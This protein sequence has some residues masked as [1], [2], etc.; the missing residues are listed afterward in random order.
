MSDRTTNTDHV[1]NEANKAESTQ[2]KLWIRD[3]LLQWIDNEAISQDR[4]RA[5]M[6]N[7]ALRDRMN[8]V[9]RNRERQ[10]RKRG[11]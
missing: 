10:A 4:S 9:E 7:H 8:R 1:T 6:I 2:V 11:T 3:E 5:W